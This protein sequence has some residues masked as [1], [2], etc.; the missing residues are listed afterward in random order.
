MTGPPTATPNTP[1][2]PAGADLLVNKF[3][4]KYS[5]GIQVPDLSLSP[6]NR[7]QIIKNEEEER[8]EQIH[9]RLRKLQYNGFGTLN[10]VESEF[11]VAARNV[12]SRWVP[13]PRAEPDTLPQSDAPPRA[14]TDAE[15]QQLQLLLLNLLKEADTAP[16]S[17]TTVQTGRRS[18]SPAAF[19]ATSDNATSNSRS[20]RT[21]DEFQYAPSKRAR[22]PRAKQGPNDVSHSLA[23]AIDKVPV[24][25]K[26]AGSS[27]SFTPSLT[28]LAISSVAM[29]TMQTNRI[30]P[31]YSFGT[32]AN[33]S[34]V[35]MASTVFSKP[36]EEELQHTQ[37]TVET[38]SQDR[39]D[40]AERHFGDDVI[41]VDQAFHMP[42]LGLVCQQ[43]VRSEAD[44]SCA[45]I[46]GLPA[47]SVISSASE[48]QVT[49]L[50]VRHDPSHLVRTFQPDHNDDIPTQPTSESGFGDIPMPDREMG[51]IQ[52]KTLSDRLQNI[53]R[54]LRDL[55]AS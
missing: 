46:A 13:K 19:Q 26:V 25:P 11:E 27:A 1:K 9:A 55:H 34:R 32:S 28:G 10:T 39:Q 51:D 38:E 8:A 41:A 2:K 50:V 21:S 12:A 31:T 3:N 7:R 22:G 47:R 30:D 54:K 16:Q 29:S 36:P 40:I 15:R 24:R 52:G 23:A 17:L 44:A 6:H 14:R 53:W 42:S 5:L 33:T 20:K 49:E 37:S 4:T 48:A 43:D 35:S 45:T 18:A